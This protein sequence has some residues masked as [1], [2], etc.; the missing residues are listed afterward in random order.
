MSDVRNMNLLGQLEKL[1]KLAQGSKL[2]RFLAFPIKY[3]TATVFNY[4]VYPRTKKGR[5]A[6]AETFFGARMNVIL[7]ASTDIY[8]TMGKSHHSETRFAKFLIK[9]LQKGDSFLDIGAHFGYFSLLASEIVGSNGKVMS[10]EASK[11]TFQILKSNVEGRSN[12][13]A[14]NNA[15]SDKIEMIGFYEFPT[16]YSE[17]NSME[18]SQFE[19]QKWFKDFAPTKTEVQTTTINDIIQKQG[20]RPRVIKIDVEG[21]EHT[22]VKGASCLANENNIAIV[23]EY[24]TNDVNN[25]EYVAASDKLISF[26]YRTHVIDDNGLLLAVDDVDAQLKQQQIDSENVVFIK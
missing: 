7:P 9:T 15:L 12:I 13:V 10:F 23:L 17:Y 18:I 26:G 24:L 11:N 1:E 16:L 14:Y 6:V 25:S 21:A 22:V 2:T 8:L 4:L 5:A 20:F 19:G 3:T